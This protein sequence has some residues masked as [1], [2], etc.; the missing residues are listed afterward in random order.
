MTTDELIRQEFE[1]QA[2]DA[3]D[4]GQVLARFGVRAERA[5]RRRAITRGV[6]AALA[7]AVAVPA[8]MVGRY[9]LTERPEPIERP[10]P[11][12]TPPASVTLLYR[13]TWVPPGL[14]EVTRRVGPRKGARQE[15]IWSSALRG[16]GTSNE[17]APLLSVSASGRTQGGLEDYFDSLRRQPEA[18]RLTVRGHPA[19]RLRDGRRCVVAWRPTAGQVVSVETLNLGTCDDAERV[20]RSVVPD[21]ATTVVQPLSVGWLPRSYVTVLFAVRATDSGC[22]AD[23][24]ASSALRSVSVIV[25][26][27]ALPRRGVPLR[28]G[29]R[30]ARSI[31]TLEP[32]DETTFVRKVAVDLGGGRLLTVDTSD[33]AGPTEGELGRIAAGTVVGDVDGACSW[34]LPAR[35]GG[36]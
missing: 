5:R 9:A 36:R 14:A 6:A 31:V 35:G 29:G 30:P 32:H 10:V 7:A 24:L 8:V 23:L 20:A 13:P 3:P 25:S 33:D 22:R 15:R 17:R 19:L 12:D 27:G 28:I 18:V 34:P 21:G 2:A 11:L 16:D 1:R 26:R 4:P